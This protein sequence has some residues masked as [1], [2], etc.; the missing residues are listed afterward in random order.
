MSRKHIYKNVRVQSLFLISQKNCRCSL[1]KNACSTNQT[2][3]V[4]NHI[5]RNYRKVYNEMCIT[6]FVNI[7]SKSSI[8]S[9]NVDGVLEIVLTKLCVCKTT[10]SMFDSIA[11]SVCCKVRTL[12]PSY[13][14]DWKEKRPH[15]FKHLFILEIVPWRSPKL[16]LHD[17]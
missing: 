9:R 2:K 8:E 12:F 11:A 3:A 14:R 1:W 16:N 10:L 4:R 7:F 13:K 15:R 17:L 6:L 5:R